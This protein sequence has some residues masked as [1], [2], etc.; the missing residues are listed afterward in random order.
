[1]NLKDEAIFGVKWTTI[2]TLTLA[3]VNV[4]KI[5]ILF[6]FL[7]KDVTE[8]ILVVRF[9]TRVIKKNIRE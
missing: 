9:P 3:V 8:N 6:R 4:L 1:M 2:W 5:S 7:S